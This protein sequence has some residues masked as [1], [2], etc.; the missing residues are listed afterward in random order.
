MA[1]NGVSKTVPIATNLQIDR[2]Y[3]HDVIP[4]SDNGGEAIALKKTHPNFPNGP[5]RCQ[6]SMQPI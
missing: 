6:C 1:S 2:S 5:N 3:F 4:A